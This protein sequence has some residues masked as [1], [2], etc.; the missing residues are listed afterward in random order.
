MA[1]KDFYHRHVKTA[2]TRDGWTITTEHGLA[3]ELEETGVPK[4]DIVLGF[5]PPDVRPLTGYAEAA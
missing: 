5:Q 4:S 3:R 2:L 1:A